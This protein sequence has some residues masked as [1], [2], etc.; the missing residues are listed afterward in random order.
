MNWTQPGNPIER[1]RAEIAAMRLAAMG[2]GGFRNPT[3]DELNAAGRRMGSIGIPIDPCGQTPAELGTTA[4]AHA[5]R[6]LAENGK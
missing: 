1:W 5:E 6:W 3:D 4:L 2:C